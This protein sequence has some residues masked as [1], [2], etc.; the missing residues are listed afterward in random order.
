MCG[1]AARTLHMLLVTDIENIKGAMRFV[2]AARLNSCCKWQYGAQFARGRLAQLTE[3]QA[4]DVADWG[5]YSTA[6]KN[7]FSAFAS[8]VG[9]KASN[10]WHMASNFM[11]PIYY[12]LLQWSI[13][14][15][16]HFCVELGRHIAEKLYYLLDI[17]RLT[18]YL[19]WYLIIEEHQRNI[20]CTNRPRNV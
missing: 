4:K 7:R 9:R 14:S 3:A 8:N 1:Y 16:G 15:H 18:H 17:Q 6:E 13:R 10:I 19:V 5:L 11:N 2:Y 20:G 12:D